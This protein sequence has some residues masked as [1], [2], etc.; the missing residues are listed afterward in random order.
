MKW[1]KLR[2]VAFVSLVLVLMLAMVLSASAQPPEKI[3]DQS[4]LQQSGADRLCLH[5]LPLGQE[6]RPRLD[7]LVG[8][9]VGLITINPGWGDDEITVRI[10]ENSID[11]NI[12]GSFKQT[13][14]DGFS[15]LIHFNFPAIAVTP[16]SV[17]VIELSV[18]KPTFGWRSSDPGV[19]ERGRAILSGQP[20]PGIDHV[21]QTYAPKPY[22]CDKYVVTSYRE[23][24]VADGVFVFDYYLF[25]FPPWCPGPLAGDEPPF[26]TF[27]QRLID[28]EDFDRDL[29]LDFLTMDLWL[30][31]AGR[32]DAYFHLFINKGY[33]NFDK[34][35]I[36]LIYGLPLG[37]QS[38]N[39]GLASADFTGDFYPD[40]VATIPRDGEYNDQ[41]YVFKNNQDN[42]FTQHVVMVASWARHAKE[43]DAGDFDEDGN[44]DFVIFDYPWGGAQVPGREFNVYLY[45]G[46]GGG[47]FWTPQYLFTPPNSI[48]MIVAGDFGG[49]G[50]PGSPAD[51]HL[52]IIVGQDDDGDPGQTWIYFG[53][54]NGNFNGPH[55]AYDLNSVDETGSDRPGAGTADAY[56][57]DDDDNLDIVATGS[58]ADP[59]VSI[60]YFVKGNGDGTFQDPQVKYGGNIKGVGS[61]VAA[62]PVWFFLK[63]VGG[64]IVPVSKV[65]LLAPWIGLASLMIIAAIGALVLRRRMG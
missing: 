46:T 14:I 31:T 24:Q 56:D 25:P 42:T 21:F 55:E 10:R 28:T 36:G 40:F 33:C 29:D 23:G 12:L 6:F 60:L 8:I 62:P 37:W 49:Y 63:A 53:D 34:I 22:T 48:G 50:G 4:S 7:K 54:G 51:G 41:I 38:G 20:T 18:T 11:G 58:T 9:D 15:G 5:Y 39:I 43:M 47:T 64:I 1:Q 17:Y 59:L 13:V 16:E 2:G 27:T 61:A 32:I 44:Y 65:E 57:L 30:S 45:R 3:V 26:T 52:D 19:Y 35:E